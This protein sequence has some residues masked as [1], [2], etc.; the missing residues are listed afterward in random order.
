[1]KCFPRLSIRTSA[2]LLLVAV[3]VLTVRAEL[4]FW[5]QE[6]VALTPLEGALFR[7]MG[8]PDGTVMH[9]RPAWESRKHLGELLE[10]TPN[11]AGL[12]ALRAR[13][14][15]RLADYAAAEADWKQAA[16]VS[17]D[18]LEPLRQLARFLPPAR[19]T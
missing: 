5:A 3:G 10:Q 4:P 1:M 11:D 16:S 19:P 14:E 13:E 18:K 6:T 12:Y 15:E 9:L 7:I 17:P 8:L 2:I